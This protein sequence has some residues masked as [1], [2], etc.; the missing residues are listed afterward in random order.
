MK[1]ISFC[2][3]KRMQITMLGCFY[4]CFVKNRTFVVIRYER[5]FDSNLYIAT[6]IAIIPVPFSYCCT[7]M[8]VQAR[9]YEF[10]YKHMMNGTNDKPK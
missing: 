3:K 8:H 7:N 2:V 9:M 1:N 4:Y 10:V 6:Y 5:L